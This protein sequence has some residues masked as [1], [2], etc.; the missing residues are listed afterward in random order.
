MILAPTLTLS[1][2]SGAAIVRPTFSRDFA[3]EKTLDNGTG[4]AITFT[5]ASNATYFDADGVLQ[6]AANDAPRFDHNPATGES[7]GL[8]IEGSRSNLHLYSQDFSTGWINAQSDHTSLSVDTS[9]NG[10]D[11]VAGVGKF[12]CTT[13]D[14][15][16][17]RLYA[18]ANITTNSGTEYTFSV[19]LKSVNSWPMAQ[20]HCSGGTAVTNQQGNA[21]F[22]LLNGT[23]AATGSGSAAIQNVGN[24]WYRCSVTTSGNT[25]TGMRPKIILV[26][27]TAEGAASSVTG[28]VDAG[29]YVWG[30]QL[31]VNSFI[32][33]GSAGASTYI[34]TTNASATRSAEEAV[35]TPVSSFF[36]VA[37]GTMF[38][39]ATIRAGG[40]VAF[41][42]VNFC[43]NTSNNEILFSRGSTLTT[44][45]LTCRVAAAQVG[46]VSFS[47]TTNRTKQAAVYKANDLA[48]SANGGAAVTSGTATIPPVTHLYLGRRVSPF[49]GRFLNGRLARVAYYPKRLSNALLQQLTT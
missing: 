43:D 38:A 12:V 25:I 33:A 40:D 3:G 20:L 15:I 36:N 41:T 45:N 30:A 23:V 44:S 11:G 16:T 6:T 21:H 29:V 27:T 7:L 8:L 18:S 35:V 47:V 48:I 31:E 26:S 5:R 1:A 14:A 24:G 32:A 39:D 22:D 4:P 10:L 9:V 13:T 34:P 46:T 42:H 49:S 17:R 37:E 2:G 19:Y 28:I